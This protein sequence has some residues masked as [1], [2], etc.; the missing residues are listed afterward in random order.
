MNEPTPPPNETKLITHFPWQRFVMT[1]IFM[2]ALMCLMKQ[3]VDW[4]YYFATLD[5]KITSGG[6]AITALS[7]AAGVLFVCFSAV[8]IWFITGS[9]RT[10]ESMFKFNAT[11]MAQASLNAVNERRDERIV[12]EKIE[13]VIVEGEPGAPERRPFSPDPTHEVEP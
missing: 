8:M 4:L 7:A 5:P 2:I 11:A 1:I 9:V 6:T 12:Q 13:H 3:Y 10:V